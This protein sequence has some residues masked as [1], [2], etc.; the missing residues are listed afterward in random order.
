MSTRANLAQV[1][2]RSQRRAGNCT[3][4]KVIPSTLLITLLVAFFPPAP[5]PLKTG[6]AS[7]IWGLS[8]A[9]TRGLVFG[10]DVVF[11]Y[12]P[13]AYLNWPHFPGANP[14]IFIVYALG[15]YFVWVYGLCRFAWSINFPVIRVVSVAT[16]VVTSMLLRS[17]DDSFYLD[18]FELALIALSMSIV[19]RRFRFS[20]VDYLLL[21]VLTAAAILLKLNLAVEAVLLF[22]S[23]LV[24]TAFLHRNA[25]LKAAVLAALL[26][27]V[28]LVLY[29]AAGGQISSWWRYLRLSV[30]IAAGYSEAMSLSGSH[31]QL[32]LAIMSL[33]ILFVV[34]PLLLE[35]PSALFYVAVPALGAILL[36]FKHA[37]VRQDLHAASFQVELAALSFVLVAATATPRDCSIVLTFAALSTVAGVIVGHLAGLEIEQP[38]R[39]FTAF[40]A[41]HNAREY[42]DFGSIVSR[43]AAADRVS[44]QRFVFPADVRQ[45]I[46]RETVDTFSFS[47]SFEAVLANG[48]KWDPRPIYQGYSAWTALL[49]NANAQYLRSRYGPRMVLFNWGDIDGRYPFFAEPSSWRVLADQ[50]D[51]AGSTASVYFLRRCKQPRYGDP[52]AVG[53]TVVSWNQNIALPAAGPQDLLVMKAEIE[54]TL[55][56]S[57]AALLFRSSPIYLE[58]LLESGE[59][60]RGRIIRSNLRNGAIVSD[61]PQNSQGLLAFMSGSPAR[62][63]KVRSICFRSAA[64]WQYRP[65]IRLRWYRAPRRPAA[66]DPQITRESPASLSLVRL[67]KPGQSTPVVADAEILQAGP[68]LSFR[69]TSAD[70]SLTFD[71]GPTFLRCRTLLI[72]ARFSTLRDRIV[73][74]FGPGIRRAPHSLPRRVRS[75]EPWWTLKT[76]QVLPGFIG[77]VPA[78]DQQLDAWISLPR[79][80]LWKS[81]HDTH[82]QLVP[83]SDL[84][85]DSVVKLDGIWGSFN[86]LHPI[87]PLNEIHFYS[88]VRR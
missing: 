71:L 30:E 63:N 70:P 87:D 28:S 11:S 86:E 74:L 48:L 60:T 69:S 29:L 35:E 64:V 19:A 34:L 68:V 13:L 83:A 5:P 33:F 72:R 20:W 32:L 45:A 43:N 31:W 59:N 47:N 9:H 24:T 18:R 23:L 6:L 50:Y 3:P 88:A 51:L 53:E 49:E 1:P 39:Q 26:P 14:A 67:W 41:V 80:P 58:T 4:G 77:I 10:R 37:F 12:G 42:L 44:L 17:V 25:A 81:N 2:N 21:T 76:I 65:A 84:G 55:A 61:C 46:Q 79:N 22:F 82:I 40:S 78:A 36:A 38:L 52:L 56:G 66:D 85:I 75:L 27:V 7:W 62:R 16:F 73:L 57:L 54:P 8:L 15:C